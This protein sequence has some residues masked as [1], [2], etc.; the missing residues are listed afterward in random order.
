MKL[1]KVDGSKDFGPDQI[2]LKATAEPN[3]TFEILFVAQAPQMKNY[4]KAAYSFVD[5]KGN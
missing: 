1:I 3:S 4:Y 2:A 5:L